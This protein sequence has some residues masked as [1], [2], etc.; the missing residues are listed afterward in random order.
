MADNNRHLRK[1]KINLLV[2]GIKN[3]AYRNINLEVFGECINP[4]EFDYYEGY[5]EE[6]KRLEA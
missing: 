4:L 6:L 1:S 3:G 2:Q 5:Q